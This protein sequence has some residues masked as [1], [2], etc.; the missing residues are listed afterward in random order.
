MEADPG[1]QAEPL[2]A[3]QVSAFWE[4]CAPLVG[5]A[6]Q[7]MAPSQ[8]RDRNPYRRQSRNAEPVFEKG[9]LTLEQ[10]WEPEEAVAPEVCRVWVHGYQVDWPRDVDRERLF[11]VFSK[12]FCAGFPMEVPQGLVDLTLPGRWEALNPRTLCFRPHSRKIE[13]SRVTVGGKEFE[14]T[15]V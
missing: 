14:V 1:S 7:A 5:E 2:E 11:V 15:D 13:F 6:K 9:D 3:E 10:S 8:K 4:G 12:P